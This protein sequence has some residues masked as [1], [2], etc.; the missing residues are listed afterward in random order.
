MF[1]KLISVCF[2]AS[3]LPQPIIMLRRSGRVRIRVSGTILIEDRRTAGSM[4]ADTV[5]CVV[6]GVIWLFVFTVSK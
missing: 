2:V 4:D 3:G 6:L 1:G 5:P